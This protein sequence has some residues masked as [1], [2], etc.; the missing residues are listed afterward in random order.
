M[1]ST[2]NNL[3][4]VRARALTALMPPLRL[5]LSEWIEKKIRLPEGVSALSGAVRLWPS[6]HRFRRYQTRTAST[7]FVSLDAGWCVIA[8]KGAAGSAL[9][10]R[11][12][13][14]AGGRQ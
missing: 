14:R 13:W 11:S 2:G 10:P 3:L 12:G 4:K 6:A 7:I 9:A 8:I 5:C 1:R